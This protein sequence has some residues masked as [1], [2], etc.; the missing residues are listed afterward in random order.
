MNGIYILIFF[1]RLVISG[2]ASYSPIATM[3]HKM[4]P[5][6]GIF[7]IPP[8]FSFFFIYFV[9]SH[10]L[11]LFLTLKTDL[12][13]QCT[14]QPVGALPCP[15][16]SGVFRA[17]SLFFL[18]RS[19][20]VP[21]GL[22]AI[23]ESRYVLDAQAMLLKPIDNLIHPLIYVEQINGCLVQCFNLTTRPNMVK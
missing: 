21:S 5:C 2:P 4:K 19:I 9:A 20:H 7:L 17:R 15:Q 14:P 3:K 10:P 16:R 12:I 11:L 8:F 1:K 18:V 6:W 22:T 23:I 13:L